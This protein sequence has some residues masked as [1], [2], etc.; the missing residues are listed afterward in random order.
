MTPP[1]PDL[2]AW[3]APAIGLGW[4]AGVQRSPLGAAPV[5]DLCTWMGRAPLPRGLG[6][7]AQLDLLELVTS[8]AWTREPRLGWSAWAERPTPLGG[9]WALVPGLGLDGS[10]GR[11][12]V[13][14]G[15]HGDEVLAHHPTAALGALGRL[16]VAHR[17]RRSGTH[18]LAL[19]GT[20]GA[21]GGDDLPWS[22]LELELSSLWR[23]GGSAP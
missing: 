18:S 15:P 6:L 11:E 1:P 13:V 17:G 7:E 23:V 14:E 16:G 4:A 19:R 12:A 2:A 10:F 9:R 5:A 22:R 21:R 8:R 20:L 3:T